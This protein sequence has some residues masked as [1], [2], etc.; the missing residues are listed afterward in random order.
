MRTSYEVVSKIKDGKRLVG[1]RLESEHEHVFIDLKLDEVEEAA[2]YKVLSNAWWD[3][4]T[5][6]IRSKSG[7]DFRKLSSIQLRDI[8]GFGIKLDYTGERFRI[9]KTNYELFREYYEKHKLKCKLIGREP[10]I[11]VHYLPIDRIKAV[12]Y[13]KRSKRI[14]IPQGVTEFG[15]FNRQGDGDITVI[16][17]NRPD[18]EI[19][20]DEMF[21][22]SNFRSIKLIVKHPEMV[23]GTA[24]MFYECS[25]LESVDFG[26]AVYSHLTDMRAMFYGCKSLKE[27][28]LSNFKTEH[29]KSMRYIFCGCKSLTKLDIGHFNTSNVTDMA[30]M[31]AGCRLIK[32]IDVSNFDTRN[33]TNMDSM[34]LNCMSVERLELSNFDT[35]NVMFMRNMFCGCKSLVHADLTNFNT[36]NVYHMGDIFKDCPYLMSFLID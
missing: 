34:F 15:L 16:I 36:T 1:Y 23:R 29:V 3:E 33:V 7:Y 8:R 17:D 6:S 2:R 19:Y 31:F 35:S 21:K 4:C 18:K 24:K 20:L 5:R 30:D 10:D 25:S 9:D 32:E 27:I 28:N 26:D 12:W 11:M 13:N 14:V 22:G